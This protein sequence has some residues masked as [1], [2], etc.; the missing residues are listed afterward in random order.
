MMSLAHVLL[1][2]RHELRVERIAGEV[3]GLVLPFALAA[4][5]A[6]PV[7]LG[8]DQT[9]ISRTGLPAFWVISLLFG[10]Q[11]AWRQAGRNVT[12]VTDQVRLAGLD[13]A[14]TFFGRFLANL[15]LLVLFML[16][17]LVGSLILFSPPPIT[18]WAWLFLAAF[19]FAVGLALFATII[20]DL[21]IGL[22]ARSGLAALLVAPL[23]IP[24]VLAA[25]QVS[26]SVTAVQ[27]QPGG[28]LAWVLVLILIDLIGIITGVL[29]A[30]PLEETLG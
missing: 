25:G 6:L 21:T 16:A 3:I 12:A 30:R 26:R 13:P 5:V 24:L 27:V 19:L 18:S 23:A 22:E 29:T 7:A 20:A 28:I 9:A 1:I 4:L 8:I 14:S 10:M 17:T 2:L 15:C 11:I